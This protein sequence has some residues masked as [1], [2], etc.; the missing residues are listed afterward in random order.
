[1]SGMCL[2]G[3]LKVSGRCLGG[4]EVIFLGEISFVDKISEVQIFWG[5]TFWGVKN[6]LGSKIFGLK[7]FGSSNFFAVKYFWGVKFFGW[8]EFFWCGQKN[9]GVKIHKYTT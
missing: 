3:V 2:E 8:S 5:L 6:I 9:L 4:V 7:L 1:M